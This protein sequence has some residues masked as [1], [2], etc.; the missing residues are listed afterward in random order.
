MT[1]HNHRALGNDRQKAGGHPTQMLGTEYLKIRI[2]MKLSSLF[3][4][5]IL[6]LTSATE[7]QLTDKVITIPTPENF[8][9][10]TDKMDA[11][12]RFSKINTDTQNDLIAY[13]ISDS[14]VDVALQGQMPPLT[15]T[16][17]VK[18]NLS[19]KSHI[20]SAKQFLGLTTTL[21]EQNQSIIDSLNTLLPN[22]MDNMSSGINDE[23]ETDL[24]IG[25]GQMIPLPP[26]FE[27]ENVFSYSMIIKYEIGTN[28]STDFL[29][30]ASTV[31]FINV[32]GKVSFLYASAPK[33]DLLWT[34]KI[35]EQW[36]HSILEN[37][38]PPPSNNINIDWIQVV[39][40]GCVG[41]L[42]ALIFRKKKKK[43]N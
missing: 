25:I 40:S 42:V 31:S 27:N 28:G 36:T 24:N 14:E 17:T 35:S 18:Q 6:S 11:V 37:N 29:L 16:L 12:Y 13:Y 10:V 26:H 21:K 32:S 39:I 7:F 20:V 41:G 9:I 33:N 8:E 19:L 43:T 4:V 23:F 5:L 2:S 38:A 30:V 3:I 34:Q 22:I 15:R 1:S